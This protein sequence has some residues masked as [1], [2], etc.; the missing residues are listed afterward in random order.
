MADPA[1]SLEKQKIM[2]PTR[3]SRIAL[4]T[5]QPV[6]Q[7]SRFDSLAAAYLS[8]SESDLAQIDAIMA[9]VA[10]RTGPTPEAL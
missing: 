3:V 5:W 6:G 4:G 2:K 1:S 10:P 7:W 9:A 8:L